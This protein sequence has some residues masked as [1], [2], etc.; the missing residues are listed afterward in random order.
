L[1]RSLDDVRFGAVTSLEALKLSR[2]SM[3]LRDR[4]LREAA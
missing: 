1:L 2:S 3:A 4:L